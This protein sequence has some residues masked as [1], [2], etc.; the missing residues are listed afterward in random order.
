[1]TSTCVMCEFVI[2]EVD[3][4]LADNATEVRHREIKVF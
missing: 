4:L 2:R 3:S 1:M